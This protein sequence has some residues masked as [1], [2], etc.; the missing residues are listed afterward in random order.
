MN[1]KVEEITPPNKL[2][3]KVGDGGLA[4]N[5]IESADKAM[6]SNDQSFLPIMNKSM[7]NIAGILKDKKRSQ[8]EVIK[9]LSYC[10]T[11][12]KSQGS[13]F[14]YPLVTEVSTL[15]LNFLPQVKKVDSDILEIISA[16]Q[17]TIRAIATKK[18]RG[19][20]TA[21][22]GTLIIALEQA[23]DR[24]HRRNASLNLNDE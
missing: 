6:Q 1:K 16:Y 18:L 21:E 24:Y 20:K 11:Q 22:G 8:K 19:K 13:M 14:N 2:K 4:K 10:I 3:G 15:I 12:L 5:V 23:C 7:R 17:I 9:D